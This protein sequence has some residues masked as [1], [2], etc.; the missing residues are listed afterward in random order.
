MSRDLAV[1]VGLECFEACHIQLSELPLKGQDREETIFYPNIKSCAVIIE[2]N[3]VN[4]FSQELCDNQCDDNLS[5]RKQ[6]KTLPC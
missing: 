4:Y 3:Q 5:F 1:L 6:R 2:G